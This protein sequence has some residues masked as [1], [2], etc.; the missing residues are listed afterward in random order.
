MND[1]GAGGND[2]NKNN[3]MHH[4]IN[5]DSNGKSARI[6]LLG[7]REVCS[8]P[9]SSL[10]LFTCKQ[11]Y[12]Q[13]L[14]HFGILRSPWGASASSIQ[15]IAGIA[16][17]RTSALI[18]KLGIARNAKSSRC[19]SVIFCVMVFLLHCTEMSGGFRTFWLHSC[20]LIMREVQ[21]N[22]SFGLH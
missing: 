19:S 6:V 20:A 12:A 3:K 2:N 8:C 18:P 15:P 22:A 11:L 21:G 4:N 7:A 1:G 9:A 17:F 13:P 14:I 5:N 16:V 10:M